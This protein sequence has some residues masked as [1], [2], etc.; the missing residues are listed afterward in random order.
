M[1][2]EISPDRLDR[3]RLYFEGPCSWIPT[4]VGMTLD[5]FKIYES[6]S[7]AD[8]GCSECP[9]SLFK[10]GLRDASPGSKRCIHGFEGREEAA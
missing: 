5:P 7:T 6:S 2:T 9:A 10:V 4:F 8:R 1:N 3:I